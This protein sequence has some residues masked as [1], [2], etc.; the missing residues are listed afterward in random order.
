MVLAD[1]AY[2]SRAI[3]EH[4]RKRGIQAVIPVP[5]TSGTIGCVAEAG[6][7][8]HRPSTARSTSSATPSSDAST[9]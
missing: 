8:G 5:A 4:L 1:K 2:S 3:R 6:A 7:A 9:A